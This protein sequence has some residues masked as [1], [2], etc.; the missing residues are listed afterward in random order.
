M[1]TEK[2]EIVVCTDRGFVMP[3]GVMIYSVCTNNQEVEIVFHVV[4]DDSLRAKDKQDLKE[5]VKGFDGKTVLFYQVD[6][7]K[8]PCFPN[9]AKGASVTQAAYYR[10]LISE[11][12]P[13]TIQ[14]VLYMDGDIIV[15]HSLLPLWN[16]DL[17]DYPL[18]AVIDSIGD[19]PEFY[20]RLN[21]SP[22]LGYFNSGVMLINLEYW[23]E[24]EV[25]KDF[26]GILKEYGDNLK[27]W[28]QDVLNISFSENKFL[29]PIKYNFMS[30]FLWM[31]AQY[32]SKYENEVLEA[33]KDPVIVHFAGSKPWEA[34]QRNLHPFRSTFFKFQNQ[35]KWKG[36]KTDRRPFKLRVIN[37]VA[38]M[39]RKFGLKSQSHIL[40]ASKFN[41]IT[42][43]D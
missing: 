29:L 43:I 30:G 36:I 19:N 12:L 35:T 5:T 15:R 22:K 21:Y 3:T 32:S 4:H 34:Y 41:D 31:Q 11:I 37:F 39:L 14:K 1:K 28:D 42:P 38:D 9:T 24:H 25:V 2:I 13:K 7:T 27:F 23:R 26:L 6:V 10:L 16:T 8:F 17:K 18:G 40:V 33:R 20:Q